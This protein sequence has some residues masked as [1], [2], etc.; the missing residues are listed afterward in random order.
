MPTPAAPRT[1]ADQ[2]RAWSD[3]RLA[4]LLEA[5]PDLAVPAPMDS[6][7]LASRSVVR[8]SVVRA[9]DQLDRLELETLTALVQTAPASTAEL[10]ELLVAGSDNV[11]AALERLAGLALIWGTEAAWRPVTMLAELIGLPAG[12]PA[13][14]IEA[15]LAELDERARTIL[16]HLDESGAAGTVADARR[17]IRLSDASTPTEHLLARR[18]LMPRDDRHVVVPWTVRLALRG[19]ASTRD[20]IDVLPTLADG[21]REQGMIDRA[22]AGAAYE[23]TRRAEMLLD[24]WGTR[25]PSGLRAG[26]LGIRELR[27]AADLVHAELPTTALVIETLAAA[28]LLALGMNDDLDSAW[29]PTDAYDTWISSPTAERWQVLAQAWLEN[30][31]L[32]SA[33]GGRDSDRPINA[34]ST[35]LERAWLP[36]DRTSTLRCLLDLDQGRALAAGTGV[37]SLL[38]RLHH[39]HPRRPRARLDLA[40]AVL[41]EAATVGVTGLNGVSAFGSALVL[42]EDPVKALAGL[43]PTPID[44]VLIQADLTAV[45]PGPLEQEFARRLGLLAD[46]ES[47]GG[48]TVYRF[49]VDSVRRSFDSGWSAIEVKDFLA[50]S[51]RT[52]VPQALD[53]LVDDVARRFGT[54]RVGVAESFLRS[55]DETALTELMHDSAASSLRLRRIAPTVIVSDVP[56]QVLLPRLRELGTAPVVEAADGTVRVARPDEHR[57]RT[58]RATRSSLDQARLAARTSAVVAAVRAGDRAAAERPSRGPARTPADVMTVLREA[59]EAKAQVWIGY[60][61]NHGTASERVVRPVEVGGGQVSAYDERSDEIRTFAV[62]RI[63]EVRTVLPG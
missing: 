42:G 20:P 19:G 1:L 14:E 46:V 28:R 31:R 40:A 16:D 52:P 21:P 56:L 36:G 11:A 27:A 15:A 57:S 3:E 8:V 53:F 32:V 47:R 44:H 61:D 18:L 22:A 37:S 55:D 26:G 5:R 43:L 59:A 6:A 2:L 24:A 54:V 51:S 62:H 12:P 13:A 39:Q 50:S 34:L 4:A 30:P 35:G 25:P 60:L 7:Q 48:A 45:A 23:F 17:T 38:A 9:L 49:T 41:D 33:I 63:T 10:T 29:L 58:P